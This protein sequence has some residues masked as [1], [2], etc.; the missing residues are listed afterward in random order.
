MLALIKCIYQ[1]G[2]N[3]MYQVAK[4]AEDRSLMCKKTNRI[5]TA[6]KKK[7]N[8]EMNNTNVKRS[9]AQRCWQHPTT[10]DDEKLKKRRNCIQHHSEQGRQQTNKSTRATK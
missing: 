6:K 8:N 4:V 7:L 3:T 2:L 1:F 10:L 9:Q 5:T